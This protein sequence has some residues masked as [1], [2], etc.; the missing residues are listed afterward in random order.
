MLLLLLLL[1]NLQLQ[2]FYLGARA[3]GKGRIEISVGGT[4]R[5][6]RR[7][8]RMTVDPTAVDAASS[9]RGGED[10]QKTGGS[11]GGGDVTG[12]R[13]MRVMVL[14]LLL[15]LLGLLLMMIMVSPA[16]ERRDVTGFDRRL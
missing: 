9:V 7:N 1:L 8:V 12:R 16:V 14:L 6:G 11:A 5:S 13:M 3:A 4:E 15:W 2:R 10:A